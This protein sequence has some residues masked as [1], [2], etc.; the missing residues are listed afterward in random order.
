MKIAISSDW[1]LDATTAGVDR[2]QDICTALDHLELAIRDEQ[3]DLFLFLGDLTDPDSPRAW[4]AVARAIEFERMLR[5][6]EVGSLW[7]VG[8]H[9]VV[10]DGHGSHVLLPL[11]AAG[12]RVVDIPN[13]TNLGGTDVIAFPYTPRSLSYDPKVYLEH[14]RFD[15][16][17]GTT[18]VVGH[19][20]VEGIEPG[21]ESSE[22]ARGR[23]VFLPV[24]SLVKELGSD[25]LVFN[26]HYH[27]RQTFSRAGVEVHVPGSLARLT[28]GERENSPGYL[29]VEV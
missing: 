14:L 17:P 25:L 28:R 18:L 21:S 15:R 1:H 3:V 22:F 12:A 2:Y 10:E 6:H 19:L 26:G 29:I 20:N 4:R 9:D 16:A 7:L 27:R 23:E 24:D 13:A 11:R 8:N 5:D